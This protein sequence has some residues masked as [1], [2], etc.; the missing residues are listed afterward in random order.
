MR[1][2]GVR[3]AADG[4]RASVDCRGSR[5]FHGSIVVTY[6]WHAQIAGLYYTRFGMATQSVDVIKVPT[7]DNAS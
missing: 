4:R 6:E 2:P 1:G 3:H 5:T 7:A